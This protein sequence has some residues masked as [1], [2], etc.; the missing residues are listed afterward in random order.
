MGSR[1]PTSWTNF[2]GVEVLPLSQPCCDMAPQF[3]D[4]FIL[5]VLGASNRLLAA[6]SVPASLSVTGWPGLLAAVLSTSTLP[7]TAILCL[8]LRHNAQPLRKVA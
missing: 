6:P 7:T 3:A 4:R 1:Q 2:C 5:T 8:I